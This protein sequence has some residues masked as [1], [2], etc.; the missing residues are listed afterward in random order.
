MFR[1]SYGTGF[2]AP[3]LNQ[4]QPANPVLRTG[5]V[6]FHD[7]RRGNEPLG[8][9]LLTSGG[10]PNLDPEKSKNLSYGVVFS[11]TVIDGMRISVDR[12]RIRKRDNITQISFDQEGIDSELLVPGLITRGQPTANDP[13]GVGPI[14]GFNQ[15]YVN[16]L[17]AES[18]SYDFAVDYQRATQKFG[19][20]FFA[21]AGTKLMRNE[22]QV[23]PL[24]PTQEHSGTFS[25]PAWMAN[26]SITW[27]RRT[28]E[29]SWITHYIDSFWVNADHSMNAFQGSAT[30]PSTIYHDV[31]AVIRF[32]GQNGISAPAVFDN[33]ELRVGVDNVFD[34]IPSYFALA[35]NNY[36]TWL[37]PQRASYYLTLRKQF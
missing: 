21:A 32:G 22:L 37:D 13:F 4:L 33:I 1:A 12:T 3:A 23:A 5:N 36:N 25:S 9:V 6:T 16:V 35:S 20:W 19:T 8:D 10:N 11:P 31:S 34:R 2:V 15:S 18:D 30:V 24:A 14:T 26:A 17:R 7:P 28:W 27:S 29:V